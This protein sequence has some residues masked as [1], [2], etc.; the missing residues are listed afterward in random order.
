LAY[1]RNGAGNL[2]WGFEGVASHFAG[3]LV[4]RV[5]KERQVL[6]DV[7]PR[8]LGEPFG[9]GVQLGE[10]AVLVQLGLDDARVEEIRAVAF[11]LIE[12]REKQL[13]QR[14]LAPVGDGVD[15][16][17]EDPRVAL[18]QASEVADDRSAVTREGRSR[19]PAAG[20]TA[21]LRVNVR[22]PHRCAGF[23]PFQEPFV[24]ILLTAQVADA[25]GIY[26]CKWPGCLHRR[27]I[28]WAVNTCENTRLF[29]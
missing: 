15:V 2:L 8:F 11:G 4:K 28:R 21:V 29:R 16:E 3:G 27:C 5:G 14:R 17:S 25:E 23:M 6:L 10:L 20:I 13:G 26:A 1:F 12:L 18:M 19:P 9:R 7:S 24:C 22:E